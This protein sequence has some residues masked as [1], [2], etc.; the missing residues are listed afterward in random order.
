MDTASRFA[1]ALDAESGSQHDDPDLLPVRLARA[2]AA[3]LPVDGVGLSIHRGPDLRTP[4]AASTEAASLAESLQFTTGTGPCLLAAESRYPVFATEELMAR[5]WPI[6]HDLLVTRT[7]LRSVLALCLPAPLRGV[8][9][10]DLF[11]TDPDG[12]A[13]I[14]V[15]QARLVAALVAERL[16]PAGDWSP[17][18]AVEEPV[19]VRTTAARRRSRLWTA[20]GLVMAALH[21]P[22]TDALGLL[23]AHAYATDRTADDLAADLVARRIDP[24]ELR[25]DA[26]SDR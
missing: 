16:G 26:D 7:P 20:V 9:G 22:F 15:F 25:E 1:E 11:S 3:V 19:W 4:L 21:V 2:A 6:F 8:A 17:W 23:R 14:D 24:E 18:P 12:A 10:M 5:R 13:T